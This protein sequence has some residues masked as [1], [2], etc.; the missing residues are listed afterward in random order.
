MKTIVI[1]SAMALTGMM[2]LS[3]S[4]EPADQV[5]AVSLGQPFGSRR[6]NADIDW[7]RLDRE[8]GIPRLVTRA[9]SADNVLSIAR[10]PDAPGGRQARPPLLEIERL[11][12]GQRLV[13]RHQ[14]T[15]RVCGVNGAEVASG[16]VAGLSPTLSPG[17]N[18]AMLDFQKKKAAPD[19]RV[20]V[21]VTKVYR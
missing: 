8:Y 16:N 9:D 12:E 14:A 6:A 11:M 7:R 10:R 5:T 1:L 13:C 3:P 4:P 2:A 19:F 18:R 20:N 21:K 17:A 15:W